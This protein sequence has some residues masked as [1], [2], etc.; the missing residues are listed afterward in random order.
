MST[1][2]SYGSIEASEAADQRPRRRRIVGAVAVALALSLAIATFSLAAPVAS[3][4]ELIQNIGGTMTCSKKNRLRSFSVVCGDACAWTEGEFFDSGTWLAP[5]RA[6]VAS[7]AL[8]A[9]V[10]ALM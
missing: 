5:A 8:A 4:A 6:V 1:T 7:V 10:V 9:L 3:S 2:S